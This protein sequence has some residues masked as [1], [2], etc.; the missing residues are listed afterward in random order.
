MIQEKTLRP[1]TG[2]LQLL[3]NLLLLVG[4]IVLFVQQKQ[5]PGSFYWLPAVV[6]SLAWF[7]HL[8]GSDIFVTFLAFSSLIPT[9]AW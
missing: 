6:L 8:P 4:A 5:N 3:V 9:K 2:Y 7:T 1:P